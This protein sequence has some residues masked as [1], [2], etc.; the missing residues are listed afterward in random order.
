MFLL[1][2][3]V[4]QML[5]ILYAS[6]IIS[7]C[8]ELDKISSQPII[9]SMTLFQSVYFVILIC[10]NSQLCDFT[11]K[12]PWHSSAALK[13]SPIFGVLSDLSDVG[14]LYKYGRSNAGSPYTSGHSIPAWMSFCLVLGPLTANTCLGLWIG[15]FSEISP[16]PHMMLFLL[17]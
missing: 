13:I 8:K 12:L 11:Y 3:K 5:G 16:P 17:A 14:G 1:S 2:L 9:S 4:T 10:M 15:L 7:P 6:A